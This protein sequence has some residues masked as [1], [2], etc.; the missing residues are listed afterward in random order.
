MLKLNIEDQRTILSYKKQ[1]ERARGYHGQCLINMNRLLE[2]HNPM[3]VLISWQAIDKAMDGTF[4][5][6]LS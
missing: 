2:I 4:K 6:G 1:V 3:T 5:G